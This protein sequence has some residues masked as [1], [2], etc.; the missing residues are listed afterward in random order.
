LALVFR[1]RKR[2]FTGFHPDRGADFRR[3]WPLMFGQTLRMDEVSSLDFAPIDVQVFEVVKWTC[4]SIGG[5]HKAL[6]F[7]LADGQVFG[8]VKSQATFFLW[9]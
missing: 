3:S 7:V 5:R 1:L 2:Q 9:L 6:E 8:D 4:F